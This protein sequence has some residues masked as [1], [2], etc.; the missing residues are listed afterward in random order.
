MKATLRHIHLCR[1]AN[2]SWR[3]CVVVKQIQS[4]HPIAVH[5]SNPLKCYLRQHWMNMYY[6]II[7]WFTE[8][9]SKMY[10][11][12]I[13]HLFIKHRLPNSPSYLYCLV[14]SCVWLLFSYFRIYYLNDVHQY[15]VEVA[16]EICK[17]V[18]LSKSV[19]SSC[20]ACYLLIRLIPRIRI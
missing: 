5:Q 7:F 14:N 1:T 12:T 13:F 16:L 8:H 15:V 3:T 9:V 20:C 2:M 11:V 4:N 17:N 19:T 10:T 18:V 6:H